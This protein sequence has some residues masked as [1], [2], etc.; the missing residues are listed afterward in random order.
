MKTTRDPGRFVW[1][2]GDLQNLGAA[3]AGLDVRAPDRGT[4]PS[5]KIN[6]QGRPPVAAQSDER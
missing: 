1:G 4:T 5:N 2:I 3:S 6:K